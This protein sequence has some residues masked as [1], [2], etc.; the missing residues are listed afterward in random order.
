[1]VLG[2]ESWQ[3]WVVRQD[4]WIEACSTALNVRD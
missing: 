4:R 2:E 1:M 3:H